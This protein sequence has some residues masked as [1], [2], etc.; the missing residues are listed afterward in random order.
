MATAAVPKEFPLDAG[1]Q[2]F[3]DLST[4]RDIKVLA[5]TNPGVHGFERGRCSVRTGTRGR[6][7]VGV[8]ALLVFGLLVG[9]SSKVT[10]E[11]YD[12]VQAG[13]SQDEVK[14]IL[15]APTESRDTSLGP[16]S[17]GTWVWK[18]GGATITVQFL[19][20]KVLGK[21]FGKTAS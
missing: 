1:H 2:I 12:K 13:M 16:I 15:G 17:G 11:N 10:Q 3:Y 21:Q 6:G 20:G 4:V 14:A 8:I 18:G 5:R 9:C 19:G 7:R